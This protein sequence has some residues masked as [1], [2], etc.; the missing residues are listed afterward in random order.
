MKKRNRL[1]SYIS[2]YK[3]QSIFF[4]NFLMSISLIIIPLIIILTTAIISTNRTTRQ[5]MITLAETNLKNTGYMVDVV[6][7][8]TNYIA[9]SLSLDNEVR[10]YLFSETND[11]LARD[12]SAGYLME[13]LSSLIAQNTPVSSIYIFSE[14]YEEVMTR[15]G[16]VHFTQFEDINWLD[17]YQQC[18]TGQP[19]LMA[20]NIFKYTNVGYDDSPNAI[21][22]LKPIIRVNRERPDGA[23]LINIEHEK[24]KSRVLGERTGETLYILQLNGKVL[25]SGNRE[26]IHMNI[27]DIENMEP[28][29]EFQKYGEIEYAFTQDQIIATKISSQHDVRYMLSMP[30]THFARQQQQLRTVS[31]SLILI[32]LVVAFISSLIISWNSY[33]PIKRLLNVLENP[34]TS[35]TDTKAQN[36]IKYIANSIIRNLN[37]NQSLKTELKNQLEILDHTKTAALQAQINPHFLYNTLDSIRWSAI[38][39]NGKENKVSKMIS[40]LAGLLRLS[41]ET[42]DNIVPVSSEVKHADL[43][44]QILKARYPRKIKVVWDIEKNIKKYAILKLCLQP[45]IENAYYHGIKPTRK[46]GT[47]HVSGKKEGENLR[48]DISDTGQGISPQKLHTLNLELSEEGE[49]KEDHIGIRNV[50]Q[51][52]K[53]VFGDEYG[54]KIE[55]TEGEGTT[56]SL[57]LPLQII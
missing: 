9:G 33:L 55:S 30:L 39:L 24:L 16:V 17:F 35:S 14:Q 18:S 32:S 50:H 21:T 8:D 5:E 20:R 54:V 27:E 52:I 26:Q 23:I 48:I 51:R 19:I 41:L 22:I 4:K 2:N 12:Q 42:D 47:I 10:K 57:I 38:D 43:F 31:I 53:L 45:L 15:S 36:E 37:S 34:D 29:S 25:Y 11:P 13:T 7:Q 44:L 28:L 46:A 49:L 1:W 6:F 3:L 56:I 40:N